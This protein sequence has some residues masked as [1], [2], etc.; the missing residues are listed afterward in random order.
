MWIIQDGLKPGETV[1]ATGTQKV[2]QGMTVNPKPF[3]PTASDNSNTA[4]GQ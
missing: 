3:T 2:T 1:M 4:S